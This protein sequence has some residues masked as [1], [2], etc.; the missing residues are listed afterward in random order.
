M[1]DIESSNSHQLRRLA[2]SLAFGR[3]VLEHELAQLHFNH[4]M[5]G[6]GFI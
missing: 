3:K 2:A 1:I 5:L 4:L 6:V